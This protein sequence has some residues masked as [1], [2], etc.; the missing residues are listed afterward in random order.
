TAYDTD[1]Y[2]SEKDLEPSPLSRVMSQAAPGDEWKQGSGHEIKFEYQV[3]TD[4]DAVDYYFV[5]FINDFTPQLDWKGTYNEGRLYKTITT[6]ENGNTI[7]E[8]KNKI[9]QVL[10]KRA[11]EGSNTLNTYYVYDDFGNLTY[12]IPPLASV[13]PMEVR[14]NADIR[15]GLCYQYIYDQKN[16]L[17]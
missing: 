9:G 15:D 13:D 7:E 8:F 12:V 3:N 4:A 10:L 14:N 11:Y 2:Y 1:F 6:D 17:I 5:K 16:R